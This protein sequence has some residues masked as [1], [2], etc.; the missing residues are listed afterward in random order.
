M[1][2]LVL[3]ALQV[4]TSFTALLTLMFTSPALADIHQY[5]SLLVG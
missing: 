1:C 3:S 4:I 2:F 5:Q